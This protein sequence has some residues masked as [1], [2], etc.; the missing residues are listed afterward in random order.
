MHICQDELVASNFTIYDYLWWIIAIHNRIKISLWPIMMKWRCTTE[1]YLARAEKCCLFAEI[2]PVLQYNANTGPYPFQGSWIQNLPPL[3]VEK[4]VCWALKSKDTLQKAT[5]W[6]TEGASHW[7]GQQG[8]ESV[9]GRPISSA[10]WLYAPFSHRQWD[11]AHSGTWK[12]E[13]GG[14]GPI[15]LPP[16]LAIFAVK[17]CNFW[18]HPGRCF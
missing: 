12:E 4:R 3:Y 6:E 16:I 7:P 13:L 17:D 8:R 14:W 1:K 10:L 15:I 2:P 5:L 11:E 9:L 18:V